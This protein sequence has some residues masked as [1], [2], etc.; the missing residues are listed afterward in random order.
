MWLRYVATV[1]TPN[2]LLSLDPDE[3]AARVVAGASE[4]WVRRF[5]DELDRLERTQPLERFTRLWDLSNA[6]AAACFG[7]SRQAFAKWID[8]GS[9]SHRAPD[10]ADVAV[11]TDLLDRY[12]RRD[13]IPA[14]VRRSAPALGGTS[15]LALVEKGRFRK[16]RTA[17]EQ[18]FDLR[19]VQ[20]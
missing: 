14:V 5:L 2:E 15:L 18:M 16:A 7:I 1:R 11:T 9:P 17:V 3:A 6:R 19:R 13:R 10:V 4:P 12:L 20:P 8:A